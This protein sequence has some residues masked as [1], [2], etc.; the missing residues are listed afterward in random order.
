MSE[1][2]NTQTPVRFITVFC[3]ASPG[4]DPEYVEMAKDL[5][6]E[7]LRR[8]YGLVYGGGSFGLMGAIA[9]TVHEGGGRV[10]GVIPEAL[11]KIERPEIDDDVSNDQIFG[12]EIVVKDMHTRKALMNKLSSAFITM[13]GGY[14]TMEELLEIT[15][16]SQLSIHTKPVMLFNM[17]GYFTHLLKFIEHSV[18][19]KFIVDWSAGVIVAGSTPKEVLDKLE[20][21]KPP[22]SRFSL[23]WNDVETTQSKEDFV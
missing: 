7:M 13:P 18:E 11:K 8:N 22:A 2:D 9:Q 5:G 20:V 14:G 1:T 3:G 10:I 15:T 17:K 4:R 23:K 6:R 12:E 16:W 21:Y 19:E